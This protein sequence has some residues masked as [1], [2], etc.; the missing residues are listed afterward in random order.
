MLLQV[1]PQEELMP[2]L[3]DRHRG[4]AQAQA[5]LLDPGGGGDPHEGLPGAAWE[6]DDPGPVATLKHYT[7]GVKLGA[8]Q[9][10]WL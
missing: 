8:R 2:P 1:G 10:M 4:G 9:N 3:I 7:G 5:A 6:D